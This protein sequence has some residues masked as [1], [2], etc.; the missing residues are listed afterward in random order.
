[1]RLS[2]HFLL[3]DETTRSG[4]PIRSRAHEPSTLATEELKEEKKK[5]KITR[6]RK[7]L[8]ELN[9]DTAGR[10]EAD[11]TW[12]RRQIQTFLARNDEITVE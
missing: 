1:M 10:S 5:K 2:S 3:S 6:A 4:R 9:V 12:M 7:E 11:R 8:E